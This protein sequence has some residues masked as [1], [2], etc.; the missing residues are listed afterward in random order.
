MR[1]I[2]ALDSG[3]TKCDAL[4]T[5]DDGR[6]LSMGTYAMPGVSGRSCQAVMA[7]TQEVLKDLPE[8]IESLHV[9]CVGNWLPNDLFHSLHLKRYELHVFNEVDG[10]LCLVNQDY[11]M[12]VLAGTGSFVHVKTR[13]GRELHLDGMGPLLGDF[14]S[15]YHIGSLAMRAA[16][17]SAWHPDHKTNLEAAVLRAFNVN[18]IY[19]MLLTNTAVPD[20]SVI[21]SLA[22]LVDAEANNGDHIAVRILEEAA[23]ALAGT[24]HDTVQTLGI[25]EDSYFMV[26]TGGVIVHSKTYWDNVCQM[27]SG[28]APNLQ[29]VVC[30]LPPVAG[31]ALAT[32]IQL[33]EHA[34]KALHNSIFETMKALMEK[35][36][37]GTAS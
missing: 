9:A 1:C 19:E 12:V 37:G 11:G 31:I 36:A 10:P 5:R 29:P 34:P 2:L 23:A 32:L 33:E 14:G 30:P 3:G 16:S 6:V 27:V 17:K 22:S 35:R 20:R 7:A 4:L 18:S 26:G 25:S 28:F 8:P 15:G 13:D 21:A 24:I